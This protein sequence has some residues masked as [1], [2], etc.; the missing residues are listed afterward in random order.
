MTPSTWL[1]PLFSLASYQSFTY[2]QFVIVSSPV[3]KPYTST[4]YTVEMT[5]ISILFITAKEESNSL[6]T[7]IYIVEGKNRARKI[8]SHV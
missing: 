3:K 8:K 1:A 2:P 7:G 6:E 4:C 5:H